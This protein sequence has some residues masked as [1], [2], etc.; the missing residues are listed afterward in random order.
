MCGLVIASPPEKLN[1]ATSNFG[2]TH[3][4][5]AVVK[6]YWATFRETLSLT[7]KMVLL[8]VRHSNF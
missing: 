5:H 3:R 1:V 6:R 7:P 4:S 2:V 8:N